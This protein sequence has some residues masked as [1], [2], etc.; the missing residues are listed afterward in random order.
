MTKLSYAEVRYSGSDGSAIYIESA[1]PTVT[2]SIISQ[3]EG[4]GLIIRDYAAPTVQRNTIQDNLSGGIK[5]EYTSTGTI[6]DNLFWGNTGYAIYMDASCY[7]TL[8]V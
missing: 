7:P 8:T 5:L 2:D 3:N 6:S 4:Y 1:S